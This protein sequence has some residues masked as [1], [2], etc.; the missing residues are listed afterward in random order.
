MGFR[1]QIY[2]NSVYLHSPTARPRACP[3]SLMDRISDSGSDDRRSIRLGGTK[4]ACTAQALFVSGSP[5][6]SVLPFLLPARTFVPENTPFPGQPLKK[7]DL[8][9]V[10]P[11][12]PGTNP[13]PKL[14][15]IPETPLITGQRSSQGRGSDRKWPVIRDDPGPIC[16]RPGQNGPSAPLAIEKSSCRGRNDSSVPLATITETRWA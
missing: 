11:Y 9:P 14:P 6:S 7:V 2:K 8:H 3:C 4:R 1:P 13:H 5:R 12:V 15:F 10:K 16:G